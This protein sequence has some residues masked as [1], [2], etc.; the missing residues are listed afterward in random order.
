MFMG[1]A[2]GLAAVQ[3][4]RAGKAVQE[5]DVPALQAK[6]REQ[7]Q[8][9]ELAL[10]PGSIAA[11]DLPGIVVDDAVA[12]FTGE[13]QASS[14]AGGIDGIYHHDMNEGKGAKSARF[15]ARLPKDGKYEVRFA[16]TTA[17]NRATNVPVA[18]AYA[19]GE[20]TVTVNEKLAPAIDKA[21]VSLGVFRFTADKPAVV[22]IT[23][24]NTDGYV[25][26][27]AIQFLPAD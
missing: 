16:Y 26:V 14:S 22:T 10:P 5:V 2:C 17:P 21:F 25:V 4:L 24:A 1:Q 8:V 15:E 3:A 9:L 11:K 7:K 6:L 20:Q 18:I 19:D 27:D 12:Q 13:W 23:T